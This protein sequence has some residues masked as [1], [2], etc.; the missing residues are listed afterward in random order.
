MMNTVKQMVGIVSVERV[1]PISGNVLQVVV[2]IPGTHETSGMHITRKE[3]RSPEAE[4][5]GI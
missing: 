3:D 4:Y 5:Q 1:I 2:F